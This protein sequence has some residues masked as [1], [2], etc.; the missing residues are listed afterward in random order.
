[1]AFGGDPILPPDAGLAAQMLRRRGLIF[2]ARSSRVSG[3]TDW[4]SGRG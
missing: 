1:V 3:G 2:A 4:S